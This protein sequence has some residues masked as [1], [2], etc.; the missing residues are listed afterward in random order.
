MIDSMGSPEPEKSTAE[1]AMEKVVDQAL[2]TL[3][4]HFDAVHIFGC[5]SDK[6]KSSRYDKGRGNHYTRYGMI[7]DWVNREERE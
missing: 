2:N 3:A 7:K 1:K 6:D 4:E 5:Y